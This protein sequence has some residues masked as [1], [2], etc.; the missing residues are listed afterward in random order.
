MVK[1]G[2]SH[3]WVKWI[4]GSVK[5]VH[6]SFL[7]NGVPRGRVIPG[8]GLRQGDSISLNSMVGLLVLAIFS[9]WM[10]RLFS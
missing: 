3:L 1:L 10:T 2:F 9:L 5:T 6:Y 7:L 4:M 8:R